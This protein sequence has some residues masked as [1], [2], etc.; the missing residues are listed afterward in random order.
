MNKRKVLVLILVGLGTV[1]IVACS[2]SLNDTPFIPGDNEP[3]NKAGCDDIIISESRYTK[4]ESDE[5]IFNGMDIKSDSLILTVQYGGG[6][7]PTSFELITDGLFMESDPV[8]LNIFLSFTDEDPCE[9]LVTRDLCFDLTNLVNH[10]KDSYQTDDGT[11][12]LKIRDFNSI[13]Y[14]F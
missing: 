11:I 12:I 2:D 10:Y 1:G 4:A 6:C 8:Q 7:G 13:T 5:F 14:T 9:M 3:I